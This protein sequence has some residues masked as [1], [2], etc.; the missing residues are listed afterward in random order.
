M[1]RLGALALFLVLGNGPS[2]AEEGILARSYGALN[3]RRIISQSARL[4]P[5]PETEPKTEAQ[6]KV[7][8]KKTR[9]AVPGLDRGSLARIARYERLIGRYAEA[10]GL[11]AD[12]VRALIYVES[13]GNQAAV[14]RRG[15]AGLM[16][17]MPATARELGVGDRFDP[18]EN[19]AGG[20]A[21]LKKMIDRY[22]TVE[23]AL[24]AYNAG[25]GAVDR[26][27]M[28]GETQRFVPK[29]LGVKR[30]LAGRKEG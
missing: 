18:E 26:G 16:Q 14:S 21:Y 2:A 7:K 4:Q 24:W 27:R 11:D 19:I 17:L 5:L 12:L 1:R 23:T 28:P 22:H 3:V 10:N 30:L 9:A 20:T 6:A 13:G 8:T 15:A 29:V 25:P